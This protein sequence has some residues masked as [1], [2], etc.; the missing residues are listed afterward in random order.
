M[1]VTLRYFDGCPNWE[2]ARERLEQAMRAAAVDADVEF[3]KVPTQ[4]EA[5]RLRFTGSPT[6]LI[7][8]E[9]PFPAEAASFGFACRVYVT[10]SGFEGSPSVGQ[11]RDALARGVAGG[12]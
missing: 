10:E 4:E 6:V 7:D 11:L 2:T 5:E 9:D 1:R 3:E 12:L 8:G